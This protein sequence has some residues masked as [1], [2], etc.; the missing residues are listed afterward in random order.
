MPNRVSTRPQRQ[1]GLSLV[2]LMI[3]MTLGLLLIG[4]V[5]GMFLSTSRN[6][7]QD[8]RLSR[9]QEN[10]RYA[11]HV[12]AQD[13]GMA[14][15]WGPLMS[16]QDINTTGRAC[17]DGS[18]DPECLGLAA[19]STL[20]LS[21]DCAPATAPSDT[22]WALAIEDP[23]EIVPTVSTGS[24]ATSQYSCIEASDFQDGSDILVV[25]RVEGQ[26]LSSTRDVTGDNGE[27]FIR[28]NGSDAMLFEYQSGLDTS[29][30]SANGDWRYL[31]NIYYIRNHFRQDTDAIP[32]LVRNKLSGD[33]I[34]SDPEAVAQGIEYFHVMF[35]IDTD[36]DAV[37][38]IFDAAP[39]LGDL[40]DVTAARIH[41][42]ARSL[43]E[44]PA[45]E[46]DRTY[47]L[48]DVTRDYSANPDGFYRRVFTTTVTLRNQRNR[49]LTTGG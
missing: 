46:N 28:T 39:S 33:A 12:L 19:Q 37:A 34:D 4:A 22:N 40:E 29:E 25:K 36:G 35:G 43:S 41:I 38:N 11:L 49:I 9:M 27:L 48:G 20:T 6:Y 45:Y 31:S 30:S 47:R 15:Y 5:A 2:E 7:N 21:A 3:A 13:L 8:E 1:R 18:T 44:D 16:G 42:L 32:T 10:A 23:I 24:S 26:E 17:L 14:G